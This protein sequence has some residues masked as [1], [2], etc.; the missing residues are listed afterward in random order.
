[1]TDHIW[2]LDVI[3][4]AQASARRLV[5]DGVPWLVYELPALPFDRRTT[6]SLVFENDATIRRVRNYPEDWRN[7][8]DADLWTLSWNT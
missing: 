6:A 2:P 7:L 3:Y 8:N 5:I 4:E 1:M